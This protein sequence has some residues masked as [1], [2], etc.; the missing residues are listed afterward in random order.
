MKTFLQT[1]VIAAAGLAAINSANAQDDVSLPASSFEDLT[2]DFE[3]YA[4]QEPGTGFF[5]VWDMPNGEF[6]TNGP[7]YTYQG[8]QDHLMR[9][10]FGGWEPDG[11]EDVEIVEL[12]LQPDYILFD[13][14]DTRAEANALADQLE[15]FGLLTQIKRV[16]T[17]QIQN[18]TLQRVSVS[19]FSK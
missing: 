15:S 3:V 9:I 12:P 17:I 1:L 14:V 7:Y 19:S 4:A 6:I 16:S 10:L 18:L 2:Y 8:A 5:I 13:T 11:Y